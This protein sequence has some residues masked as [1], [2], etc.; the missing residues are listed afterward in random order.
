[1]SDIAKPIPF[2][3][4]FYM[5]I[6]LKHFGGNTARQEGNDDDPVLP[7]FGANLG[8]EVITTHEKP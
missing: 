3:I 8:W 4:T 1:M 6:A 5:L 2:I 7:K